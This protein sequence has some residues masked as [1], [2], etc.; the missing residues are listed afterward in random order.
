MPPQ[1]IIEAEN[2]WRYGRLGVVGYLIYENLPADQRPA[3][4]TGVL[5]LGCSVVREVPNE[6]K[7]LLQLAK[8]PSTW[9]E[10]KNSFREI[11]ILT[12]SAFRTEPEAESLY[13]RLLYLAE[14]TA[15]VVY[16]ASGG[17]QPFDS[18]CGWWVPQRSVELIQKAG[19]HLYGPLWQALIWP[20]QA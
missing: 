13:S 2:N 15:K 1:H 9:K 18:D 3:W 11:R 14:S 4:A 16:N 6:I 19:D 5:Q 10:A 8:N 12:V 17:E 7:M 20:W